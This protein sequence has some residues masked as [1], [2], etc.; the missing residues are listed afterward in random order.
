MNMSVRMPCARAMRGLAPVARM[1]SPNSVLRKRASKAAITV[2]MISRASTR[3][4]GRAGS[5]VAA[6]SGFSQ[7]KKSITVGRF[8]SGIL[9]TPITRRLIE[10]SAV[11]VRMPASR[12]RIEKRMLSQ[13]VT[14]PARQPAT[15]AASVAKRGLTPPAIIAAATAAPSGKV[16]STVRSGSRGRGR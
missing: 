15:M 1:A 3:K 2:T 8:I 5:P 14:L 12:C 16:P 6:I 7:A 11:I 4:V 9:G 13:A 10:N